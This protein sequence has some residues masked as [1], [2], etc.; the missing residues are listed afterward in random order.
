[1]AKKQTS[2]KVASLAGKVL[3]GSVKPTPA[4]VKQLAA[5]ALGQDERGK[6]TR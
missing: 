2:P 5:S 6:R 1:M 3:S 4:Q